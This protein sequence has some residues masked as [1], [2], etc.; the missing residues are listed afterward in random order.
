[1]NTGHPQKEYV[2]DV[3]A[4]HDALQEEVIEI[5]HSA[6]NALEKR[7]WSTRCHNL[8][9][10]YAVVWKDRIL[11]CGDEDGYKESNMIQGW[12]NTDW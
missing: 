7:P 1:M 4:A 11:R 12:R 8:A 2:Q 5:Y 6:G 10:A 3:R 9:D